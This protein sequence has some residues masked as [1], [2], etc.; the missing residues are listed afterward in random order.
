MHSVL[1]YNLL[2]QAWCEA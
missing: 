1:E 2:H